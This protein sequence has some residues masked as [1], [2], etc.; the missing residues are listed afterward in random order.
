MAFPFPPFE[1]NVKCLLLVDANLEPYREGI[2][3]NVVP[4]SSTE[5]LE[6]SG[7]DSTFPL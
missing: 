3:A 4:D 1:S 6:Q 7:A 5:I 2:L